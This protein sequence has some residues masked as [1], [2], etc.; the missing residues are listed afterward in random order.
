[1]RM[2]A[3][4][5]F[6]ACFQARYMRWNISTGR[7]S[8]DQITIR[9]PAQSQ[10]ALFVIGHYALHPAPKPRRM[11]RLT[12]MRQLVDD[13]VVDQRRWRLDQPPIE[14]NSPVGMARTPACS[15]I[16]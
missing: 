4:V 12:Q 15:G 14:M 5:G 1:M 9:I 3:T 6:Y 7:I 8:G 11:I 2:S 10:P 13:D 16:R